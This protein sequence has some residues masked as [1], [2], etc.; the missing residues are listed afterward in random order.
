MPKSSNAISVINDTM[1]MAKWRHQL[2]KN[3]ISGIGVRASTALAIAVI[4]P[5]TSNESKVMCH[6]MRRVSEEIV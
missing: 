2:E 4:V 6:G 5:K 1:S 3:V